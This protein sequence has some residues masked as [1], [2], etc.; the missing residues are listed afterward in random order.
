MSE[1]MEYINYLA[2]RHR[3]FLLKWSGDD[4]KGGWVARK[5]KPYNAKEANE[6]NTGC[7]NVGYDTR[8]Y[9]TE[10]KLTAQVFLS[11]SQYWMKANARPTSSKL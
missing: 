10:G 2:R 9:R 1:T 3:R 4:M 5:N 11:L 7:V 6:A 8:S